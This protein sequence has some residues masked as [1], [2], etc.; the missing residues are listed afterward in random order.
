MFLLWRE[1]HNPYQNKREFFFRLAAFLFFLAISSF[2]LYQSQIFSQSFPKPPETIDPFEAAGVKRLEPV[3]PN[4]WTL[5]IYRPENSE[6][7]NDIRCYLKIEDAE[8]GEDV[9]LTAAKIG[10]Q[11]VVDVPKE[12][13][14]DPQSIMALFNKPSIPLYTYK[15]TPFLS[16]GMAMYFYIRKGK[17]NIS[18][19]TPKDKTY[20][21]PCENDGDWNSN[22]FYYD[23]EAYPTNVLFVFPTANENGFY[24]GSWIISS[25]APKF[26]KFTQPK[27]PE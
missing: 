10:Y 6:R 4:W 22:V 20:D 21:F 1:M 23:N 19:T 25:T 27:M 9:T 14:T 7:M 3:K 2:Q 12:K 24:D 18:F 26:Y 17:F 8:T 5:I 11:Y 16:G 13:Q 15:K